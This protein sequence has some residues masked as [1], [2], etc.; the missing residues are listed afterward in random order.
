MICI[1]LELVYSDCEVI[2]LLEHYSLYIF[3]LFFKPG[4][5]IRVEFIDFSTDFIFQFFKVI[6]K[7]CEPFLYIMPVRLGVGQVLP[8]LLRKLRKNTL[9]FVVFF[10]HNIHNFFNF[11]INI[12]TE[13]ASSFRRI[14][15]YLLDRHV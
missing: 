8:Q 7:V 3:F 13:L 14:T 12:M 5:Q 4:I 6:L 11:L 15:S 9:H 10:S 2:V 1:F